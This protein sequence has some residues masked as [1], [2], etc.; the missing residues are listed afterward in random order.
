L[1][2]V[3]RSEA[4]ARE[5]V[6]DSDDPSVGSYYSSGTRRRTPYVELRALLLAYLSPILVDT[7]LG[8]AMFK[9]QIV[10]HALTRKELHDL[11]PDIMVGLRLFV[12][13]RRLPELM[14][15]LAE[16]IEGDDG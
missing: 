1:A 9:R 5:A 14:L 13:E 10:P 12:E 7:V 4:A 6:R 8:Q 16:L 3:T 11:G 2:T 15:A